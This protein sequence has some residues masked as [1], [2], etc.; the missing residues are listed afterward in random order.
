[1][2]WTTDKLIGN[3]LHFRN[4]LDKLNIWTISTN[5]DFDLK[6][7][8]PKLDL[9]RGIIP[10]EIKTFLQSNLLHTVKQMELNQLCLNISAYFISWIRKEIWVKRC[11]RLKEVQL[12]RGLTKKA[13]KKKFKNRDPRSQLIVHNNNYIRLS[14]NNFT[15]LINRYRLWYPDD[16]RHNII[17]NLLI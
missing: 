17:Q 1:M 9:I 3:T 6:F 5:Y 7:H 12:T 14:N 16:G 8:I 4:N 2:E 11:D 10:L 15:S 13:M